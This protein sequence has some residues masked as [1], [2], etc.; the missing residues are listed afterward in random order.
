MYYKLTKNQNKQSKTYGMWYGRA[1]LVG[2][3]VTTDKLAERI[4]Q[5][6]TVTKPDILAVISALETVIADNIQAGHKVV[7]DNFGT[8]K[9]GLR[10]KPAATPEKFSPTANVKSIHVIFQPITTVDSASRKHYNA[11]TYGCRVESLANYDDPAAKAKETPS[12]A[13]ANS[14]STEA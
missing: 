11:F 3:A 2:R 13:K 4:A 6:C 9:L 10:T 1:A 12:G 5:S 8:F 7:L 14:G